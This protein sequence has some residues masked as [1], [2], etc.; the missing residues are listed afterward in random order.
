[1]Y[2]VLY[3]MSEYEIIGVFQGFAADLVNN[4]KK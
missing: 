1:M 4:S 2:L 3:F